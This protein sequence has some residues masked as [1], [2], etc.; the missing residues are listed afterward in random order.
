MS[1]S[2]YTSGTKGSSTPQETQQPRLVDSSPLPLVLLGCILH[3]LGKLGM[4]CGPCVY[5]AIPSCRHNSSIT[6]PLLSLPV[7][8]P[9]NRRTDRFKNDLH[10]LWHISHDRE[11]SHLNAMRCVGRRGVKILTKHL[12]QEVRTISMT[13][14]TL[15]QYSESSKSR[16]KAWRLKTEDQI[17]M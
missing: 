7:E 6:L 11:E 5:I 12:A 14:K 3:C 10:V 17:Y 1:R 4:R 2:R 13:V 8:Q 15:T 16:G 9:T